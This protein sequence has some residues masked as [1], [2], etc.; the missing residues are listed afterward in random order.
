MVLPEKERRDR[1]VRNVRSDQLSATALL[2]PK[3]KMWKTGLPKDGLVTPPSHMVFYEVSLS[4]QHKEEAISFSDDSAG[5][6]SDTVILCTGCIR[7]QFLGTLMAPSH[8]VRNPRT[9]GRHVVGKPRAGTSVCKAP[10]VRVNSL[11]VTPAAS[12]SI[13]PGDSQTAGS[14]EK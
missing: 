13:L 1:E 11:P 2:G 4:L 9:P 5:L 14:R 10:G 7:Q 3:Y 12:L 8:H 6:G